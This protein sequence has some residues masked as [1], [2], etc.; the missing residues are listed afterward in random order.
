MDASISDTIVSQDA[1][2]NAIDEKKDEL[3]ADQRDAMEQ[4]GD[5]MSKF[6]IDMGD[7][8][9]DYLGEFDKVLKNS[10]ELQ[11]KMNCDGDCQYER[12]K[13][14]R[15]Q[16]L[17]NAEKAYENAPKK[18]RD[19]QKKYYDFVER[20]G[21]NYNTFQKEQVDDILRTNINDYKR[22]FSIYSDILK[23]IA[24]EEDPVRK[25]NMT[26]YLEDLQT[27]YNKEYQ[28]REYDEI[29]NREKYK[30]ADRTNIYHQ[31]GVENFK[32]Y[33]FI[34]L[35]LVC[36]FTGVYF[37]MFLYVYQEYKSLDMVWNRIRTAMPALILY[38]MVIVIYSYTSN[39]SIIP[40]MAPS[41]SKPKNVVNTIHDETTPKSGKS[42]CIG[43]T[44][45]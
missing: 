11:S 30:I 9:K 17:L 12:E 43:L 1:I 23:S 8:M 33:N 32:K 40:K 29:E 19:Y 37:F 42:I 31:L 4:C 13:Q 25:G 16:Q 21:T 15:H 6:K 36:L 24:T 44:T 28:Q 39:T 34:L 38:S 7:V 26:K 3:N 14:I 2:K 41:L 10:K 45:S 35:S 18:L 27:M 22:R 5:S 20:E